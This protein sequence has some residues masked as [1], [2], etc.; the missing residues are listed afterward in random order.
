MASI[1]FTWGISGGGANYSETKAYTG[2]ANVS[3]S[4]SVADS[5]TDGQVIVPSIDVSALQAVYINSDQAVVIETNDGSSP[6]D[7]L[8][9]VANVPYVWTSDSYD[10]CKLTT[11]I[12]VNGVYVTNASGAAANIEMEF[13]L[14]ATPA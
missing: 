12:G 13:L 5:T 7:T 9:L 11:D 8:T 3:I 2:S 4:E 14:D 10:T 1:T 6:D